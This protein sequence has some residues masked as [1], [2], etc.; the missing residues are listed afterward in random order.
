MTKRGQR[1]QDAPGY[2][3]YASP[4]RETS[5]IVQCFSRDHGLMALAAKGAKRPY[6]VLRPVLV[7]FQPLWLSW[8][9]AAEVR[10]LVRAEAG[11]VRLLAGRAMMSAWYLN[12]LILRLLGRED[13]HPGV[14]DAYEMALDQLADPRARSHAPALRRFEWLLLAQA[15]YGFDQPD[16]DFDDPALEP[17]LRQQLRERIDQLLEAPLRTRQVLLDLQ[18]Y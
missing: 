14:Y 17:I 18:R 9:G 10:T 2:V 5:L 7:A 15:G 3:L 8:S 1:V 16:P 4:W 12:E 13:P 11:P 6:S